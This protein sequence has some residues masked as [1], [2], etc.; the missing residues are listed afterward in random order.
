MKG[1][2]ILYKIS[3]I[4]LMSALI[5]VATYFIKV[6]YANVDGYFNLSDSLIIFLT[7]YFGPEIG[8]IS[9]IISTSLADLFSGFANC[10]PFTIVAKSLEAIVAFIT[11]KL[12][13]KRNILKNT[14][15][16]LSIIPMVLSYFIFYLIT[17]NFIF[18][19]SIL[20]SSFDIIQGV[21]GVSFA[22]LL[23]LSFDKVNVKYRY[24]YLTSLKG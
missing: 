17:N 23:L 8:I 14:L 11:Y 1:L 16:Y 20:Y 21:I 15:I 9:A 6:P 24:D 12:F 13:F 19:V 7:L 3:Y 10:I 22:L 18:R 4:A 2:K 5:F